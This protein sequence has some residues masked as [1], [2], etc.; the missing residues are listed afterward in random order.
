M[1]HVELEIDGGQMS[2]IA[3]EEMVHE[4]SYARLVDVFVDALPL[5]ERSINL[6]VTPQPIQILFPEPPRRP[7]RSYCPHHFN[8]I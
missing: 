8:L 7:F 4:D 2:M 6:Y 5:H 1:H 3:L